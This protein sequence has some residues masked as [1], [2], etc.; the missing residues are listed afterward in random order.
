[1][2]KTR[3]AVDII[4]IFDGIRE[5]DSSASAL[6]AGLGMLSRAADGHPAG[7]AHGEGAGPSQLRR[8]PPPAP[9]P[10]RITGEQ[11]QQYLK[12][13]EGYFIVEYR[14]L[15]SRVARLAAKSIIRAG[16]VADHRLDD[17]KAAGFEGLGSIR[18][19]TSHR[20]LW[21]FLAVAIGGFLT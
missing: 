2:R 16:D 21:L 19:L 11:L 1:S 13:I 15:L 14:L 9:P 7:V 4:R 6:S 18:P 5:G 12:K 17:L 20:I 10:R 8:E 3:L